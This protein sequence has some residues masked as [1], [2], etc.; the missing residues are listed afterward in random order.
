MGHPTAGG[1]QIS[2]KKML[3]RY[4]VQRYYQY[5]GVGGSQISRKKLLRNT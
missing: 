4:M 2:W 5:K 3:E 1:V